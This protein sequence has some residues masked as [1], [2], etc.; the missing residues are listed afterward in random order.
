MNALVYVAMRWGKTEHTS[1]V[2]MAVASVATWSS[3]PLSDAIPQSVIGP[4]TL[5]VMLS[6]AML[7]TAFQLGYCKVIDA[8]GM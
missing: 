7:V 3:I 8:F 4:K 1:T 2:L 6:F 5:R